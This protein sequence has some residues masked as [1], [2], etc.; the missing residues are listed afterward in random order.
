L[1]DELDLLFALR[2][3]NCNGQHLVHRRNWI[4][5]KIHCHCSAPLKP[6][7]VILAKLEGT[8]AADFA[9][10]FAP[11]FRNPVIGVP[12]SALQSGIVLEPPEAEVRQ[13]LLLK[14]W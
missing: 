9:S 14:V 1:V 12:P 2:H 13:Q 5:T 7:D 4:I 8:Q 6:A 11:G 3:G 10:R